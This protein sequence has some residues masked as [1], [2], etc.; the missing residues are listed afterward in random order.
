MMKARVA[1]RK[2]L[3]NGGKKTKKIYETPKLKKFGSITELTQG[4]AAGG[5]DLLLVSVTG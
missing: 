4:N 1:K 2:R 5:A 3:Q